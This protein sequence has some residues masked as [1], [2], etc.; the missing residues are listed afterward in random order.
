VIARF[1]AV[2]AGGGPAGAAAA[3]VLARAGRSV[4]LAEAR[5]GGFK[6]G[7]SLPPGVRPLL[8]DLGVLERFERDRHLPAHGTSAAWGGGEPRGVDFIFD[9]NGQGWHVDRGRFDALL[10]DAAR[11]AGAQVRE[12]LALQDLRRERAAAWKVRLGCGGTAGAGSAAYRGTGAIEARCRAIVDAT[13]RRPAM[14]R[15]VG[16]RRH[17]LDRLVAMYAVVRAAGGD[18]DARTLVEA[19]PGGWWY[20]ALVP[21]DRRVVAF[22]TDGDLTP[23]ALRTADGLAAALD[24]TEHVVA[25]AAGDL[26]LGPARGTGARRRACAA[27]GTRLDRRG[28]RGD[29]ARPALVAGHPHSAVHGYERRTSTRRRDDRRPSPMQEHVSR[30]ASI[31]AQYE[32]ARAEFYALES[33]WRDEPFWARRRPGSL[34]PVSAPNAHTT[35]TGGRLPIV[36]AT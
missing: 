23:A 13:G 15:R 9:P 11:E 16:A 17:R 32:G 21:D 29:R 31:G 33:R 10:R 14:P 36:G 26:E 20:T 18:V 1:D 34:L 25:L 22:L 12:G 3:L 28:R 19:V 24:E 30:I 7:E 4:L 2:V 5:P 35:G 27:R 8:R 6:V